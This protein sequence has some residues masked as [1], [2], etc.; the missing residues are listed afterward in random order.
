[1]KKQLSAIKYPALLIGFGLFSIV[2][3]IDDIEN[4]GEPITNDFRVLKTQYENRTVSGIVS[5]FDPQ[6]QL[7]FVFSHGINKD[8]FE[9]ALTITPV[10]AQQL[11]YDA[12]NS[13]VTV[14]FDSPLD[15]ETDYVLSLTQ[16]AYGANGET[17][18]ADYQIIFSTKAFVPPVISLSIDKNILYEGN[19]ATVTA[20]L[21]ESVLVDVSFDLITSGT[22]QNGIDYTIDNTS[23]VIPAGES[24][25]TATLTILVDGD[26]ESTEQLT[27]TLENAVNGTIPLDGALNIEVNDVPPALELKGV[28]ELDDYILSTTGR[29]RAVHLK[30]LEDITDL[31]IYGI[32]VATNGADPYPANPIDY[33]FPEVS[34]SQGDNILLVRDDDFTNAEAFFEGYFSDFTVFQTTKMSQTGDDAILLYKNQTAI[35]SFGQPGTDGTGLYWEYTNSWAY[36]LGNE[37]IYPGPNSVVFAGTGTATTVDAKYPFCNPLELKGVTALLFDVTASTSTNR[38]K[39]HHLR[40]NRD[41]EDLSKFGLGVAS[42]GRDTDNVEFTFPSISVKE[43][44]QILIARI[45]DAMAEYY[46]TQCFNKFNYIY[47]DSFASQNGDDVVELFGNVN[48]GFGDIIERLGVIGVDGTGESWEYT[49]SWA[50]KGDNGIWSYGGVGCTNNDTVTTSNSTSSCPYPLCN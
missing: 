46:G 27:L 8:A 49:G 28:M 6:G 36:K 3:C 32:E 24:T 11:V 38:G 37:W 42:N 10:V 7:D 15:Y 29:V 23:F 25:A 33:I 43:G 40:I 14:G 26:T 48:G 17:M 47:I 19:Q 20:T 13:F 9:A 16:G 35:E 1:M 45:P 12:T 4:E 44:E 2:S 31:S 39:S 18:Q 41:I 22:S 21:S 34:A 50:H 5:N 30:V